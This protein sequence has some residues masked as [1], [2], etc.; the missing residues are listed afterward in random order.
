MITRFSV[1]NLHEVTIHLTNVVNGKAK[2][3][4][5][6]TMQKSYQHTLIRY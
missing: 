1:L 2:P 6:L 4:Q 3:D 5:I